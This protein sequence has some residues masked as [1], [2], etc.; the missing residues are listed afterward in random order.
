MLII[1]IL[2]CIFLVYAFLLEYYIY[3]YIYV[4]VSILNIICHLIFISTISKYILKLR[5][6]KSLPEIYIGKPR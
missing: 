1:R 3:I 5:Y 2:I 4:L 6:A